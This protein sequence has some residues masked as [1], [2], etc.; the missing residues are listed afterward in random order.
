MKTIRQHLESLPELY[1]DWAIYE[2][3]R[4]DWNTC[5]S[6]KD[7]SSYALV[8]AFSWTF[9]K[10]GEDFWSAIYGELLHIESSPKPLRIHKKEKTAAS[11]AILDEHRAQ[12]A[13]STR[14]VL[15][16]MLKGKT[17]DKHSGISGNISSR[18]SDLIREN[19]VPIV[20]RKKYVKGKFVHM[21]YLIAEAD[22][23]AL[24]ERFKLKI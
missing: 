3:E 22:R 17:L 16:A 9:T 1:R 18:I 12:F 6:K 7:L 4:S 5:E 21:Q 11:Q 20:K 13:A 14:T 8:S 19:G 10:I 23:A 24:I 15:V 2:A